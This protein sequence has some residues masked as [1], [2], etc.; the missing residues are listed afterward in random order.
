[1]VANAQLFKAEK[2]F[3][4]PNLLL[5]DA[6]RVGDLVSEKID[7]AIT[8]PPYLNEVDYLDNTRLQLYFLDYLSSDSDMRSMKERMIRANSKY[9]FTSNKDYPDN[10]PNIPT[11]D[12]ILGLCKQIAIKREQRKWGWDHPRL[13][14][15]YFTDMTYHFQGIKKCLVPDA[16]YIIMVGDR[17]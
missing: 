11:F 4:R 5:G 7:I 14:A 9:L 1:M 10:L 6:R 17:N 13:V 16:K 8:S 2:D 15:E 3:F 12:E